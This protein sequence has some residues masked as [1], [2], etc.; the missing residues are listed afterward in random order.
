M[1][2]VETKATVSPWCTSRVEAS[3]IKV[4]Y[5]LSNF[6]FIINFQAADILDIPKFL[7]ESKQLLTF[8][9][10]LLSHNGASKQHRREYSNIII[11]QNTDVA[12][13]IRVL[14]SIQFRWWNGPSWKTEHVL[15]GGHSSAMV[16]LDYASM[17]LPRIMRNT[18][19]DGTMG[20]WYRTLRTEGKW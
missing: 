3:S 10:S 12:F 19:L 16:I 14:T 15:H 2:A 5:C 20:R 13:L 18:A 1:Q 17:L 7:V 6:S 8:Q 11:C 4:R 9:H